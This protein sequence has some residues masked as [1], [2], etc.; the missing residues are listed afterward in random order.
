MAGLNLPNSLEGEK[1]DTSSAGSR[2]GTITE[3]YSHKVYESNGAFGEGQQ[4][5]NV[6]G[7]IT[8]NVYLYQNST[9]SPTPL[10]IT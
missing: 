1:R 5:V 6:E 2:E 7:N 4:N 10:Q 8:I 3:I 9:N